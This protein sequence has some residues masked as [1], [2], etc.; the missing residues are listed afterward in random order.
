MRK[1]SFFLKTLFYLRTT[2]KQI[3]RMY[4]SLCFFAQRD[5]K[6]VLKGIF[7]SGDTFSNVMIETDELSIA[8]N[9][10]ILSDLVIQVHC[11]EWDVWRPVFRPRSF[12]FR[13]GPWVEVI[14]RIRALGLKPRVDPLPMQRL[15]AWE[16]FDA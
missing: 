3:E 10:S 15:G 1:L 12:V 9:W 5:E 2:P 14:R 11:E 6:E 8:L 7:I 16:K 13:R 4:A